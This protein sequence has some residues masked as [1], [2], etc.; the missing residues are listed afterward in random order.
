MAVIAAAIGA[1]HDSLAKPVRLD[2]LLEPKAG[3]NV[4]GAKVAQTCAFGVHPMLRVAVMPTLPLL[5]SVRCRGVSPWYHDRPSK[6]GRVL[7]RDECE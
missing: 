5:C 3:N 7:R 2:T 4:M 1:I 6:N